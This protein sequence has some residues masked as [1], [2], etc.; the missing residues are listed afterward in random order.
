M[1]LYTYLNYSLTS[2]NGKEVLGIAYHT[3]LLKTFKGAHLA[4]VFFVK[5]VAI[6]ATDMKINSVIVYARVW[7]DKGHDR[8]CSDTLVFWGD[9]PLHALGYGNNKVLQIFSART[10]LSSKMIQLNRTTIWKDFPNIFL[11]NQSNVTPM[12][13]FSVVYTVVCISLVH[14]L[15]VSINQFRLSIPLYLLYL[16]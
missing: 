14:V 5:S 13:R 15:Y 4:Y 1:Y 9:Y 12:Y 11:N 2:L 8:N 3:T 6:P 16:S 7:N 10:E